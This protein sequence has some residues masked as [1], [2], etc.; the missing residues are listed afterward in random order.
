MNEPRAQKGLKRREFS[1]TPPSSHL[2]G[3]G[4]RWYVSALRRRHAPRV[5]PRLHFGVIS[6]K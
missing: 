5:T 2:L 4:M 6:E 3:S 1:F